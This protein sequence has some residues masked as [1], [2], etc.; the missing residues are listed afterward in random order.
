MGG[1]TSDTNTLGGECTVF[2]DFVI[3][4]CYFC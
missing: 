3:P 4:I 1:D 2:L